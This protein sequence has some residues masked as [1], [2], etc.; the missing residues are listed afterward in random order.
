MNKDGTFSIKVQ[1]ITYEELRKRGK[2]ENSMDDIIYGLL[3]P[4]YKSNKVKR[5]KENLMKK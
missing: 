2:Y 5:K 3:Y 1:P 4:G